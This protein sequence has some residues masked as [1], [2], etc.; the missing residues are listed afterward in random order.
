[1]PRLLSAAVSATRST[2][3]RVRIAKVRAVAVR[4]FLDTCGF[5]R[6]WADDGTYG[7]GEMIDTVGAVDIVNRHIGPSMSGRDPLQIEAFW[8]DM[9]TWSPLTGA[10][11]PQ[12]IRG[13]GGPFLAA[14]S[15][16]E[17]ALWDLAG[18]VLG[19]PVYQLLGGKVRDRVPVYLHARNV[20]EA[21]RAAEV[22]ALAVKCR[23]G[24]PEN[25][26]RMQDRRN[27][28]ARPSDIDRIVTSVEEVRRALP[29][30]MGLAVDCLGMFD[31]PSAIAL[32][33]AL[34]PVRPLFLEEVTS[35]DNADLL[36]E[37]RRASPVPIAAGENIH[38]RHGY[39]AFFE[40]QALSIA[41]PDVFKGGGLLEVRKVAAAAEVYRIPLAP[42]GMASPLGMRALIHLSATIP[43]LM[44][45]EWGTNFDSGLTSLAEAPRLEGGY[46]AVDDR[47][48]LGVELNEGALAKVADPWDAA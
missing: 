43:N 14:V 5:V 40:K 18:K 21:V 2:P 42:H 26:D 27:W 30:E 3:R 8:H 38:T 17:I 12:F 31:A 22:G 45:L 10:I 39:R 4:G 19:V 34:A 41:Q 33:R 47:P 32:A 46:V 1:M 16:I 28:T 48:G 35:N 9:W 23:Q 13:L 36:A 11:P 44:F 7:T 25:L 6:V 29:S 20:A 37:I 24:F 15:A